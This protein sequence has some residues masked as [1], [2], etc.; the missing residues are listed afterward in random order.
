M[1]ITRDNYE[2]Y[3]IDFLDDKL[4]PE[5]MKTLISFLEQNPD[6]AQELDGMSTCILEPQNHFFINKEEIKKTDSIQSE[7]FNE[8]DYLCI[9]ELEEDITRKE[10]LH[11][12]N[13]L[14]EDINKHKQQKLFLKT[15]LKPNKDIIFKN[16][17]IIKRIPLLHIRESSFRIALSIAAGFAMIV[18]VFSM[19]RLGMI[20]KEELAVI[21]PIIESKT[22][23][24]T[25]KIIVEEKYIDIKNKSFLVSSIKSDSHSEISEIA[26]EE[27]RK[28]GYIREDFDEYA[29]LEP[30][31]LSRFRLPK[32]QEDT[33][34]LASINLN[35]FSGRIE[36]NQKHEGTD[37]S[38]G[39]T[40]T[41]GAFELAQI[42]INKLAEVTE[43]SMQLS[44][45]KESDGAIRAIHF[46]S[47]LFALSTPVRK[48]Q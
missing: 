18:G 5:D 41:I 20:E 37:Q 1:K 42:G 31:G 33:K 35:E 30:I 38:S 8:F 4:S 13:L 19:L 36:A 23:N 17:S 12:E 48:K 3:F 29:L 26:L 10:K 7:T 46:E 6:L 27:E 21:A 44:A 39:R 28:S 2:V 40:R 15:K 14:K 47:K 34:S 25:D 9:A 22:L 11:L 43:G 24:E 45:D 32:N 16:K